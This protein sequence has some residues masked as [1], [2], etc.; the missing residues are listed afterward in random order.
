[1]GSERLDGYNWYSV[2]E[3]LSITGEYEDSSSK[4]RAPS[5]GPYK[6]NNDSS[7]IVNN[8]SDYI[9]VTYRELAPK[10]KLHS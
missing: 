2:S 6:E 5:N 9:S 4:N 3:N 7:I 10:M 8:D 1:L